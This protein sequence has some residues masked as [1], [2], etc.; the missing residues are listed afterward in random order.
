MSDPIIAERER[1]A[2]IAEGLAERWEASAAKLRAE[3]QVRFF[4]IGKPYVSPIADQDART[5]DAAAHGL[6]TVASLIREGVQR[7]ADKP[8]LDNQK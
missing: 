3:H 4:W 8:K 7:P 6:R 5:I 1:C 2:D